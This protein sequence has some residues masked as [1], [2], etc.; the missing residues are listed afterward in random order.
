MTKRKLLLR[1]VEKEFVVTMTV[2]PRTEP[3]VLKNYTI[4]IR[5]DITPVVRQ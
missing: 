4:S 2:L 3:R 1:W 5:P